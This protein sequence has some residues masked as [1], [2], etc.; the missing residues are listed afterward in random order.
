MEGYVE[1]ADIDRIIE[2]FLQQGQGEHNPWCVLYTRHET[3]RSL[4]RQGSHN[5]DDC[6]WARACLLIHRKL[7]V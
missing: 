3:Y 4:C 2:E 7:S 1:L 6:S 5:S